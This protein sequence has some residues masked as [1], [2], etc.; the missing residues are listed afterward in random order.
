MESINSQV[1]SGKNTALHAAC[2]HNRPEIVL[3][4]LLKNADQNLRN[5][6]DNLPKDE[7]S[8]KAVKDVFTFFGQKD[9]ALFRSLYPLA[10]ELKSMFILFVSLFV[11]PLSLSLSLLFYYSFI[12]FYF[13]LYFFR[14]DW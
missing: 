4:L 9:F 8:S 3:I 13:F 11:P 7:A 14:R 10:Y 2:Q 12:L 5:I 1:G 6:H